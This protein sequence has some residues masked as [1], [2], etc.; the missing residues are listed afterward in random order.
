MVTLHGR[1]LVDGSPLLQIQ[2]KVLLTFYPAL[3][4]HLEK[5]DEEGEENSLV[6]TQLALLVD[7]LRTEYANDLERF[8]ALL[9]HKEISFDLLPLLLIPQKEYH[10]VDAR[11]GQPRAVILKW[12]THQCG[13]LGPYYSLDCEYLESAGHSA[14]SKDKGAAKNEKK[15]G[16]ARHVENIWAFQGAVKINSLAAFPMEYHPRVGEVRQTL[17]ERGKKW[18]AYDGVHHVAYSGIAFQT[19]RKRIYVSDV[20]SAFGTRLTVA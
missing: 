13:P 11:T 16:R 14:S 4:K 8:A 19:N 20:P 5:L 6:A 17:I 9:D 12:A 10:I 18:A 15:F 1:P 2:P 3:C 7:F